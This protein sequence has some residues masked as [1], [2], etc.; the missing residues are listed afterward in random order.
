MKSMRSG[1]SSS[2][3]ASPFIRP[4]P[5]CHRQRRC[6]PHTLSVAAAGWRLPDLLPYPGSS[7]FLSLSPRLMLWRCLGR[8]ALAH[9]APDPLPELCYKM[10][11]LPPQW[12][13][14]LTLWSSRS[15]LSLRITSSNRSLSLSLSPRACIRKSAKALNAA[16][17][18][19]EALI[20]K[21]CG[22][23]LVAIFP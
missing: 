8:S 5:R 23:S 13:P 9:L 21:I 7:H 2:S 10:Q 11:E 18:P 3:W 6:P 14:A 17:S 4:F 19:E 1:S 20:L 12:S 15:T 22:E 16:M